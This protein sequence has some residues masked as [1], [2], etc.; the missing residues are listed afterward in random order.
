MEGRLSPRTLELVR[1]LQELQ[2]DTFEEIKGSIAEQ[3]NQRFAMHAELVSIVEQ[4][5]ALIP[6]VEQE[7]RKMGTSLNDMNA[8]IEQLLDGANRKQV[9]KLTQLKSIADQFTPTVEDAAKTSRTLVDTMAKLVS[10]LQQDAANM[11]PPPPPVQGG[12]RRRHRGG[13]TYRKTKTR[14]TKTRRTRK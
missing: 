14:S 12:R 10:V 3:K 4:L 9:E 11:P 5:N 7:K 1:G 8:A 13:Y 6:I 2:G